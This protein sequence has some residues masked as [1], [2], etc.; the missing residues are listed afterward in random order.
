[1]ASARSEACIVLGADG[2]SVGILTATDVGY[3][4]M[5]L[6]FRFELLRVELMLLGRC[7]PRNLARY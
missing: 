1:M 6:N 2:N 7:H 3:H 4:G 5:R